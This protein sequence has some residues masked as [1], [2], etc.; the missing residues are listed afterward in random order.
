MRAQL[1]YLLH[2]IREGFWF[3]PSIMTLAACALSALT[4][5]FD[6][7]GQFGLAGFLPWSDGLAFANARMILSTIAGSTITV[8]SLVLSL[9]LIALTL[10][11]GQL[12]P[13]LLSLFMQDRITQS[14]IGALLATFLYAL[15][16]LAN[17]GGP[18]DRSVVPRASILIALI[19]TLLSF[20]MLIAFVHHIATSLHADGVVAR[21][22]R[23]LDIQIGVFFAKCPKP[24][25]DLEVTT[26][27][28]EDAAHIRAE[29]SGY[30]QN[31]DADTL[32]ALAEESD[33]E[34]RLQCRAGDFIRRSDPIVAL[35]NKPD[36]IDALSENVR[37]SIVLGSKRTNAEDPEFAIMAIVEIGLRALSPGIN[38]PHTAFSCIDWLGDA[39]CRIVGQGMPDSCYR[40]VG[41]NPRLHALPLTL[42]GFFDT[43]FSEI[44]QAAEGNAAVMTRLAWTLRRLD[45][46]A[47]TDAQREIIG[48]HARML[49]RAG[50][51]S[52]EESFDREAL[53]LPL[54]AI[55][56]GSDR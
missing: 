1:D 29:S 12:G 9:T 54:D 6:R 16:V 23:N 41:G 25:A 56:P 50:E 33:T 49:R 26:P 38:D 11:S 24:R 21:L 15:L 40:D 20:A 53:E 55:G 17:L 13:R 5:F 10:A 19:L 4:L 14:V 7:N 35:R 44:R 30:V 3:L 36:D 37:N 39:L 28:W 52:L 8:A 51:R 27:D 42:D 48:R 22:A 32:A 46:S 45:E 34:L 31:I 47:D 43:A 18:D 2:K